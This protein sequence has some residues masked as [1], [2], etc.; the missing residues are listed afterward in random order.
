[1]Y[2]QASYSTLTHHRPTHYYTYSS[3]FN[4]QGAEK[5][6]YENILVLT[7]FNHFIIPLLGIIFYL[8]ML[9]TLDVKEKLVFNSSFYA[10]VSQLPDD[11][12]KIS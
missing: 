5:P 8:W 1:L 7:N 11:G 3:F 6:F 2:F 4:L 9:Y 12:Q 10:I